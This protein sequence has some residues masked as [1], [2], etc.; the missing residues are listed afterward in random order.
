[1]LERLF[2]SE[3]EYA[4]DEKYDS[5][6]NRSPSFHHSIFRSVSFE[7]LRSSRIEVVGHDTGAYE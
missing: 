1:M 7:K 6:D 4:I 3:S 5:G 2:R